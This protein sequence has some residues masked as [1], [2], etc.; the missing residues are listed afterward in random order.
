[1]GQEESTLYAGVGYTREDAGRN[2]QQLLQFYLDEKYKVVWYH[3][4]EKEITYKELRVQKPDE[5]L[6]PITYRQDSST[7]LHSCEVVL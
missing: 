4:K 2:L 7:G 1:M 5:T 6:V 3:F